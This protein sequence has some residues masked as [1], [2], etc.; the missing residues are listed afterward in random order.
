MLPTSVPIILQKVIYKLYCTSENSILLLIHKLS[1]IYP[2]VQGTFQNSLAFHSL[3]YIAFVYKV[4]LTGVCFSLNSLL[5]RR[6]SIDT[7]NFICAQKIVFCN[8][9]SG[10]EEASFKTKQFSF[11][12]IE[13]AFQK[14]YKHN[15]EYLI[16]V[17]DCKGYSVDNVDLSIAYFMVSLNTIYTFKI[18]QILP[19][20]VLAGIPDLARF[21]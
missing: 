4:S 17:F 13:E 1:F 6:M 14:A 18:Q 10:N 3:T 15:Q 16:A 21:S 8:Y 12:M 19:K 11:H 9:V 2:I 7:I 5:I 20:L